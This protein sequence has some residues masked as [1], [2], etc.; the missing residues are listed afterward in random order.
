[1]EMVELEKLESDDESQ[2]I[3]LLKQHIHLTNSDLAS[4]ILNNWKDRSSFFVKVFPKEYKQ[5]LLAK[6]LINNI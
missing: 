3:S 1:L 6:S 2:I 4:D 5:A